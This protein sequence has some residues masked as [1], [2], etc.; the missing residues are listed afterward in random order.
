MDKK[1]HTVEVLKI[2]KTHLYFNVDGQSY[3]IGW[4]DCSPKLEQATQIE[5]EYLEISPAGYGLHWPLI[6][7]DL[8]V[9]PLLKKAIKLT[10]DI[11]TVA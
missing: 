3:A 2:D 9:A 5:R 6:D 4:T 10:D 7:E 11:V 8:A 1:I